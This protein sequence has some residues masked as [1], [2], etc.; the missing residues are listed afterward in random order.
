MLF[1]IHKFH[2]KNFAFQLTRSNEILNSKIQLL[3]DL[4]NLDVL[5]MRE[6]YCSVIKDYMCGQMLVLARCIHC[7]SSHIFTKTF[8]VLDV[9]F[10]KIGP[11]C[12]YIASLYD[13]LKCLSKPEMETGACRSVV[14]TCTCPAFVTTVKTQLYVEKLPKY[15]FL[16][17][18]RFS[19][20]NRKQV[21]S[22]QRVRVTLQS[23]DMSCVQYVVQKEPVLFD[24][25]A[26]VVHEGTCFSS[27]H[28]VLYILSLQG[29]WNKV[30]G[31]DVKD[32]DIE[33][34]LAQDSVQ[35]NIYFLAYKKQVNV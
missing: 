26:F 34:E 27:G 9:P 15:L 17:L 33:H 25:C 8:C 23:L 12:A 30:K 29:R 31:D 2:R 35:S 16:K 7:N 28:Y 19:V 21:K 11:E 3:I 14:S 4:V 1:K 22:Y 32:V 24:L 13:C 20:E 18:A 5:E 10:L 6:S